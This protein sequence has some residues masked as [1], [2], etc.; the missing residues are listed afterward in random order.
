[1]SLQGGAVRTQNTTTAF[2]TDSD[3]EQ[4]N[5]TNGG[6]LYFNNCTQSAVT[7]T[8]MN[9]NVASQ[10]GGAIYEVRTSLSFQVLSFRVPAKS[11]S[12]RIEGA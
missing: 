5:A 8:N 11:C 9:Y 3:F 7:N 12:T 4:N 2:V 10:Q 1:M 6:G